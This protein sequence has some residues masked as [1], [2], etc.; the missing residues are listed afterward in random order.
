MPYRYLVER[1]L[2]PDV[3]IG[4]G[5]PRVHR[6]GQRGPYSVSLQSLT[7][8]DTPYVYFQFG[9]RRSASMARSSDCRS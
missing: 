3:T 1:A 8:V 6:G 2:E 7:N 9:A 5:G 4:M